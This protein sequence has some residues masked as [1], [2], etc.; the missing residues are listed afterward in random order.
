[1][2]AIITDLDV[3]TK[4]QQLR[5]SAASRNI[6][7]DLS[8]KKVRQI[9][10]TNKCYYTGVVFDQN[11]PSKVKTVDRLHNDQGYT[12]SNVVACTQYINARKG[13]MS[14]DD[15]QAI[16]KALKRKKLIT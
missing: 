10:S 1:M 4:W 2:S 16:Y 13:S 9:L 14:P 8:L 11:S 15:V 6:S 12:D 3:V 5:Q 7:F